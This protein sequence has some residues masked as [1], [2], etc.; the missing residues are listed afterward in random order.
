MAHIYSASY[1]DN[2]CN[3]LETDIKTSWRNADS[4]SGAGNREVSLEH[5]IIPN[6]EEV[7]KVIRVT[8]KGLRSQLE[9]SPTGQKWNK[10]HINED[11]NCDGI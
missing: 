4:R 5:L 3:F 6:S 8:S 9:D 7:I 1:R 11:K 10:L 2:G